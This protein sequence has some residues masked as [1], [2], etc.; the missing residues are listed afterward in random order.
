M[1]GRC[2]SL[3]EPSLA[4]GVRTRGTLTPLIPRLRSLSRWLLVTVARAQVRC[5]IR[6]PQMSAAILVAKDSGTSIGSCET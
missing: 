2:E 6:R 4:D 3:W 5:R 1:G